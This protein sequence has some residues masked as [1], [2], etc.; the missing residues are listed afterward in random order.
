M[1]RGLFRLVERFR[2]GACREPPPPVERSCV[3]FVSPIWRSG[4]PLMTLSR[5]CRPA[6]G[7]VRAKLPLSRARHARSACI[8]AAESRSRS[9]TRPVPLASFCQDTRAILVGFVLPSLR[10]MPVGFVLPSLRPMPIGFVLPIQRPIP[11]ASLANG[12]PC[13]TQRGSCD[14]C[15]AARALFARGAPR[16]RDLAECGDRSG[17][18]LP[19][20]VCSGGI[21]AIVRSAAAGKGRGAAPRQRHGDAAV[22]A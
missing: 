2:L 18:D 5:S 3:G 19:H 11:V 14:R 20:G 17:P 15:G 16:F 10:P 21:K 13:M 8:A 9:R 12:R 22:N 1:V 7:F 4:P 6:F